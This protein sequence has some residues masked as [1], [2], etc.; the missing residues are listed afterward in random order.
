MVIPW[1]IVSY[2]IFSGSTRGPEIFGTESWTFYLRNLL[3]NFNVWFVL[4]ACAGP[5][6]AIQM[7]ARGRSTTKQTHTRTMVFLTP[8][9]LWLAIFTSQPHKEERF[10]YPA[11]PLLA[12][13]SAV[14]LHTIL[15]YLGHSDPKMIVGK[16]PAK[17]KFMFVSAFVILAIDV[18]IFRT[19]GT[20]S[21]YRAPLQV[22]K[23]LQN[24]EYKNMEAA[25]CL[26]KEWYRFP[27]SYFLPAK[28]RARFV[29]SEF[30]SLLPGQFNEAAVGFGFFPG[31][32]LVP[33]GMNDQNIEDTG[34]HVGNALSFHRIG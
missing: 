24:A 10:M 5:L 8:F 32:W 11:Y 25:V 26:G 12:L 4:A 3:L 34:K 16:I 15:G 20:I 23:P 28:M 17:L 2:N 6:V 9:Y 19:L 31:T 30:S 22:Y 27:S 1:R 21:A 29:K 18:G 7:L 13:N 14:A 33:P